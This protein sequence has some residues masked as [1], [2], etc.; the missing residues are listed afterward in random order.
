MTGPEA[1]LHHC[2]VRLGR[3]WLG[4]ARLGRAWLGRAWLGR[5]RLGRV[6]NNTGSLSTLSKN[7]RKHFYI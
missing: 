3:A 4:R 7:I 2:A 5:A 6:R 1:L